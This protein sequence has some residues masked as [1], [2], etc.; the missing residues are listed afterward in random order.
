MRRENGINSTR[1]AMSGQATSMHQLADGYRPIQSTKECGPVVNL[2]GPWVPIDVTAL[3][4]SCLQ[5][6]SS[7][8]SFQG[9][10]H[11]RR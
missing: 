6:F 10:G 4:V 9:N 2:L 5:H 8:D 3:G 1:T 7:N 11:S